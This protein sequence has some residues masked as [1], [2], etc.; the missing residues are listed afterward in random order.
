MIIHYYGLPVH[1][2]VYTVSIPLTYMYVHNVPRDSY[3]LPELIHKCEYTYVM[4]ITT[5]LPTR[6]Q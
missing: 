6:P 5:H 2:H 3:L 1:V 4:H